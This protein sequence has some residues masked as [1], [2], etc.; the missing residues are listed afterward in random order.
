MAIPAK[1]DLRLITSYIW[2]DRFDGYQPGMDV[3]KRRV[4]MQA[5]GIA[6]ISSAF[7]G[8]MSR[9]FPNDSAWIIAE[10]NN[11][12]KDAALLHHREMRSSQAGYYGQMVGTFKGPYTT[13]RDG[14]SFANKEDSPALQIADICAWAIRGRTAIGDDR[15]KRFYEPLKKQILIETGSDMDATK[16]LPEK[17]IS[18]SMGFPFGGSSGQRR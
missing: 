6:L 1:L 5:T 14:I 2:W 13:L 17:T 15:S 11:E 18:I 7:D 3:H 10:N 4:A 16:K 12:V 9:S 8:V